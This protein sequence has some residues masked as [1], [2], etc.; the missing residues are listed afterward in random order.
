MNTGKEENN[1]TWNSTKTKIWPHSDPNINKNKSTGRRIVNPEH[2]H[3]RQ[4]NIKH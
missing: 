1:D 4:L 3:M 2:K